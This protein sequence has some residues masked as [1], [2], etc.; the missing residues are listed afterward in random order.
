MLKICRS[1]SE[2]DF[3]KLAVVYGLDSLDAYQQR[4]DFYDYLREDFFQVKG[5]VYAV[6]YEDER[7][8]SVLRAEPYKDGYLIEGVQ[9]LAAC[10]CM[11]YGKKLLRTVLDSGVFPPLLPVYSHVH[12]KNAASLALHLGCGFERVLEYGVFIDGSVFHHS[13]TLKWKKTDPTL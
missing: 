7:Y 13:C 1:F 3:D 5:A 9:T 11:G 12:K 6:W 4:M 10:R 2:L 8:V